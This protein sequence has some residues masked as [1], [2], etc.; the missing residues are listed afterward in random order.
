MIFFKTFFV[1]NY[2]FHPAHGSFNFNGIQE[3]NAGQSS[4]FSIISSDNS[5]VNSL[6]RSHSQFSQSDDSLKSDIYNFDSDRQASVR[7]FPPNS[8]AQIRKSSSYKIQ[9][10]EERANELSGKNYLGLSV[11]QVIEHELKISKFCSNRLNELENV[12][13]IIAD[14][15]YFAFTQN[16]SKFISEFHEMYG[17][18]K[19]YYQDEDAFLV[20]YL[21]M[22]GAYDLF[23]ALNTD[24][25]TIPMHIMP[26]VRYLLDTK[27]LETVLRVFTAHSFTVSQDLMIAIKSEIYAKHPDMPKFHRDIL[28]LVG[29]TNLSIFKD[30]LGKSPETVTDFNLITQKLVNNH[31][32]A[33]NAFALEFVKDYSALYVASRNVKLKSFYLHKAIKADNVDDLINVLTL[34]PEMLLVAFII[35]GKQSK[36][37]FIR[38][39][40]VIAL[41]SD[42][43]KCLR[44]FLSVF[45]ELAAANFTVES[46]SQNYRFVTPVQAVTVNPQF[47]EY[48]PIFEEY[49]FGAEFRIHLG[50]MDLN[51]LQASF[52]YRNLD[53]L[54]Y[55]VNKVGK[56][57][58]REMISSIMKTDELILDINR[59]KDNVIFTTYVLDL[60]EIDRSEIYACT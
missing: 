52:I 28:D 13:Q 40:A 41:E 30:F 44:F 26:C 19:K 3:L 12:L 42:A 45:P 27:P 20:R 57:R 16:E 59:T 17:K 21:F 15:D 10:S 43:I 39:A 46:T 2:F 49:G 8:T 9:L 31:D 48:C 50:G 54:K 33:L 58:A 34:D 37:I 23:K 24:D 1:L 29:K 53:A 36:F 38:S 51:L 5:E 6:K 14:N 32:T 47:Y 55:Y 56:L 22:F 60:L 18:Y 11:E 25:I 35:K 4:T 7:S